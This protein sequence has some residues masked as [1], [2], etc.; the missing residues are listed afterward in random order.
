[1]MRGD[2]IAFE[3][4]WNLCENGTMKNKKKKISCLQ[5][6]K[7]LS[8]LSDGNLTNLQLQKILYFANMLYIGVQD[9]EDKEFEA[10]IENRFVA[11]PFGPA[12][13]KLHNYVKQFGNGNVP[14]DTFSDIASIMDERK[15]AINGYED[16]VAILK[17]AYDKWGK[18]SARELVEIS[19]WPKGAWNATKQAGAEEIDNDLIRN[20][21]YARYNEGG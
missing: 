15:E 11:W 19:H 10:L 16:E 20:E 21:Y 7:V 4:R 2:I 1:M 17:I 9:G 8:E 13:E 6:A 3:L 5:G 14:V 12:V 18:F